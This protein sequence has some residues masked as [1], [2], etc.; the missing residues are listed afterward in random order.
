[1][2]LCHQLL[3]EVKQR[4]IEEL[5]LQED[6]PG[7]THLLFSYTSKWKWPL[8]VIVNAGPVVPNLKSQVFKICL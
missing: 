8:S 7:K 2:F 4:A 5:Q 3:C 6:P 1:M